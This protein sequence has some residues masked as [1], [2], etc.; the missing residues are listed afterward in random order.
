MDADP[1]ILTWSHWVLTPSGALNLGAA[2]LALML[3]PVVFLQRNGDGAHRAIGALFAVAMLVVNVTALS[4][5]AISGSFNMFHAL[6]ILSLAALVPAIVMIQRYK[7]TRK[8]GHLVT[9]AECMAWAYPCGGGPGGIPRRRRRDWLGRRLAHHLSILR[10]DVD[11]D[12]RFCS[13]T[14]RAGERNQPG[15]VPELNTTFLTGKG[16]L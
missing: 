3:G 14:A 13:P 10:S 6:A 7:R 9:P 12:A 8:G 11:L 1:S 4:T 5:Y 2:S 16:K 15:I